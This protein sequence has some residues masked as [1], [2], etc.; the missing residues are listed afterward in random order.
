MLYEPIDKANFKFW[1]LTYLKLRGAIVIYHETVDMMFM[2][3]LAKA[4]RKV[5]R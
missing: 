5:G 3:L 2:L 1:N 4:T